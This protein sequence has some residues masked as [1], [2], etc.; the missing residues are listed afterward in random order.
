[1]AD[2]LKFEE[3]L[4]QLEKLVVELEGGE[5]GLDEA[6]KRFEKGV[7][8]SRQLEASLESANRKVEQL[9]KEG[10]DSG[11]QQTSSPDE[12]SKGKAPKKATKGSKPQDSLF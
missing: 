2:E 5:L 6:M 7:K 8:L 12:L 4:G 9:L 3:V 11:A 1:M 10:A